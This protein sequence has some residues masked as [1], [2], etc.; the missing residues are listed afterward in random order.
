MVIENRIPEDMVLHADGNLLRIVYDNLLSN[1]A[2]YGRQGGS[3]VLDARQDDGQ[4]TLS[5]FNDS[6][7]GI[8]EDKLPLIFEKFRRLDSPEYAGQKGTGLGLFI[9]REIIEKQGGRIWVDSRVGEWVKFSFTVPDE[10]GASQ[11]VEVGS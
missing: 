9:C 3:I 6:E 5:V 11:L 1:A 7:A 4:V 10:S 8:P 2:K